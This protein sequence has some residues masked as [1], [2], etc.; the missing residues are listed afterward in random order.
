MGRR[1][2]ECGMRN[3]DFRFQ[4]RVGV[5][6]R[7]K[8]EVGI[9]PGVGEDQTGAAIHRG[10]GGAQGVATGGNVVHEVNL[11]VTEAPKRS[12][13]GVLLGRGRG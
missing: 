5:W 6:E 9:S 7:L 13:E 11:S 2:A 3:A 10:K 8:A 12:F 4:R 1:N